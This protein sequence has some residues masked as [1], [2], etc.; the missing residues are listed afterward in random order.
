ML[1]TERLNWPAHINNTTTM[2]RISPARSCWF[3]FA[4]SFIV[5]SSAQVEREVMKPNRMAQAALDTGLRVPLTQIISASG[6]ELAG[7]ESLPVSN[8]RSTSCA[9]N[10][11]SISC[12]AATAPENLQEMGRGRSSET[13]STITPEELPWGKSTCYLAPWRLALLCL[14]C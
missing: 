4:I 3:F 13:G 6:S 1:L 8:A 12:S 5:T 7:R 14:C 10:L 9:L 11:Q 2:M